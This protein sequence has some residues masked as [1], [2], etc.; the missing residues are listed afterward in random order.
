[1]TDTIT[2]KDHYILVEPREAEFYEIWE[3]L[4][5]LLQMPEYPKKDVIWL[6]R[7]GPLKIAYDDLYR[8]KDFLKENYPENAK[9]DKKVAM[10]IPTGLGTAMATEYTKIVENLP[11]EFKIFPDL[12]AAEKWITQ[13]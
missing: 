5:Q 7:P 8:I 12:A 13:K 9:P 3:T 10:V 11:V 6:F 2:V 1:M 4:G